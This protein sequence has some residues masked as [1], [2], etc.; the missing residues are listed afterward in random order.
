MTGPLEVARKLIAAENSHDVE[1]A[2]G[3]FAEDAFA[4]SSMDTFAGTTAVR[5]W[6]QELA[7]G[8]LY[9][10]P[11]EFQVEGDTVRWDGTI[12]IDAFR[13]LGF[14]TLEGTWE[15][16]VRQRQDR[17]L[18]LQPL[19][20]LVVQ[21]DRGQPGVTATNRDIQLR[22]ELD[23]PG[24]LSDKASAECHRIHVWCDERG[25]RSSSDD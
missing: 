22:R 16:V 21:T 17:I 7:A 2:V 6:Q 1:A 10:E 13:A 24:G 3:L 19:P 8:H 9:I 23:S 25:S 11:G 4:R 18:C 14:E 5:V 20:G 15:I 12:A